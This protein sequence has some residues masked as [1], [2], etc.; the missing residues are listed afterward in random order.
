MTNTEDTIALTIIV[1]GG[2]LLGAVG[3]GVI[4]FGPLVLVLVALV[5]L[6]T[7]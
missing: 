7:W 4:V 1:G 2:L 5:C 6:Q 3:A